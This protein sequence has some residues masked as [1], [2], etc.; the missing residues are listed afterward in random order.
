[1]L[2]FTVRTGK[3]FPRYF[4]NCRV[5]SSL[6]VNIRIDKKVYIIY[7]FLII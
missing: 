2:I 7:L 3:I 5:C 6:C 1:M 4:R